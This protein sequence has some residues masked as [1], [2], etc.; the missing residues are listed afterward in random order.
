MVVCRSRILAGEK[1]HIMNEKIR[2]AIITSHPIQYNAPLFKLLAQSGALYPGIFYTWGQ[3]AAGAKYDPDFGKKIEWDIPLLD[4][5]DHRFI[6]NTAKDAGTH[7]FRGIVN[8][9]LIGEV[10]KWAPD[11]ILIFGWNYYSH[12]KCMRHFHGKIPV[13]FRGDS[14]LLDEQSGI[15]KFV[16]RIFLKWVYSHVDYALFVG[17]NNRDYFLKHGLKESQLVFV[18]HAIDNDRFA[19]PD[20]VYTEKA[21]I[22]RSKLGIREDQVVVLFAGKLEAKKNPFFLIELARTIKSDR[23]QFL[24]IGNGKLEES[25]KAAATDDPRIRFLDFQNQQEMPVIYRMGD[26]FILPSA[27]PK[28]TWG[29]SINEAMACNRAVM[30][31]D[32]AGCAV[33]L[34]QNN[35][36]GLIFKSNG[37]EESRAFLLHCLDNK[38]I[39]TEMGKVSKEIIRQYSFTQIVNSI[40]QFLGENITNPG[41]PA[42]NHKS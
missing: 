2:L 36:N 10:E 11:M 5:Y 23:L 26:V 22:W 17:S 6:E 4:G 32:K 21:G 13:L 28:E 1:R 35:R 34:V 37:I 15:R 14:T 42:G 40:D 3:T 38:N 18:P 30:V 29:L 7:H 19:E 16:R 24:I 31:S 39:L 9:G 20:A 25:L 41:A 12:L 8:P 33:D 27:G